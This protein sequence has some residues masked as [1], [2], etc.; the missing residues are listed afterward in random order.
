MEDG[1]PIDFSNARLA[2]F[3][4]DSIN[5]DIYHDKGYEDNKSKANKLR[6]IWNE[7]PDRVVGKLLADLLVYVQNNLQKNKKLGDYQKL[8]IEEMRILSQRLM[9]NTVKIDLPSKKED[10]L[11]TLLVDINSALARNQPALVLDRLHTFSTK[12][13]RQFCSNNGIDI[14]D[15]KGKYY[16]LNSLAGSLSRYYEKNSLL[17]SDFTLLAIK[18]CISLF[19]Q[20]ND[21]RNNQS[22]AH[23]NE[24][25]DGVEAE[26]VVKTMAN[27]L[28]FLDEVEKYRKK[29]ETAKIEEEDE[30]D[31]PF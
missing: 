22:F 30:F 8:K 18:N 13:L 14:M 11:Q 5:I 12:L 3:I 27:V 23:D 21:V 31:I 9:G 26:F 1:Y 4:G 16:P 19:A 15:N 24:I 6:Q 2:K 10:N 29:I 25:L 7:E 17:Q 20:Y 28:T